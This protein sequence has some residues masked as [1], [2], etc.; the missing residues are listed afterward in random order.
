MRLTQILLNYVGNAVKF[1]ASGSIT[2]LCT[3][4]EETEDSVLARF[5]VRDTGIGIAPE[6]LHRMFQ[7]F[8]QADSS[9]TR[10]YGGTGLGLRINRYL[11]EMMGGAVGVDSTPGVG[12]SF[13]A[14]VR[15]GKSTAIDVPTLHAP[16]SSD[17]AIQLT[18]QHKG[19]RILLAEDNP[20]NQEVSLT[21]LRQVGIVAELA[22]DGAEAFELAKK[23]HY[24]LILMD[25]QMPEMDG[26]EAT[27]AI[28]TLTNYSETPIIA[29]TANAFEDDRQACLSAGMNA[30]IAK[31]VDPQKLYAALLKWL[32]HA[33]ESLVAI[34][35]VH[36]VAMPQ[37][38][39]LP[40]VSNIPE[41]DYALGLK[42]MSG[43]AQVY[44]KLLKQFANSA[45]TELQKL[46]QH[47]VNGDN[48]KAR[49]LVHTIK[50]SAGTLGASSLHEHAA[51]LEDSIR[52][53][54]KYSVTTAYFDS[55][56]SAFRS[57][58]LVIA[59]KLN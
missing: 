20:I 48:E 7:S 10:K 19:R 1:T 41:L 39:L 13:W 38:F 45:E 12:S 25:M 42:Q 8:E 56:A 5:T 49:R 14:T 37:N 2:L 53:Q 17:S 18:Q 4:E 9:T 6:H 24:D 29:L 57:F 47:L 26:L 15:F 59:A 23:N 46:Q 54:E 31:P 43:N 32:P 22:C 11:A 50:G 52:N 58:A 28:R 40:P 33:P 34:E 30:H 27:R 3:V 35:P 55:L 21:L 51:A 36:N 16:S 44:E